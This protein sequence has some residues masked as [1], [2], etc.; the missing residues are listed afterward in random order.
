[1]ARDFY[2][3]QV[4]NALIKEGWKITNDPYQVTVEGVDFEVDFEF[5]VKKHKRRFMKEGIYKP[6]NLVYL[7][8]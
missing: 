5:E 3:N 7:S 4:K 8:E 2:H 6:K 1:M